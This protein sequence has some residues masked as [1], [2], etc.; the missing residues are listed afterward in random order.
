MQ[1]RFAWT[2]SVAIMLLTL[3]SLQLASSLRFVIDREECF[4]HNVQ[5]EW[6]TVHVS[7]VVIKS[8][9]PWRTDD[10]VDLV[11]S[12]S[13]FSLLFIS[14]IEIASSRGYK[15]VF[16]F[17]QFVPFDIVLFFLLSPIGLVKKYKSSAVN[18]FSYLE[19][20]SKL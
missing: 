19:H 13:R 18:T 6:D 4:S 20:I 12:G 3:S 9:S 1:M 14:V 10:G 5:Y 11:V 2:M 8:D 16:F 7:F 15:I 17:M